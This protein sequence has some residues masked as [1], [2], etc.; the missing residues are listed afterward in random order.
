M[1][2]VK[3]KR[4]ASDIYIFITSL[5]KKSKILVDYK[6]IKQNNEKNVLDFFYIKN[7]KHNWYVYGIPKKT[8]CFIK[9]L[10]LLIEV[11]SKNKVLEKKINQLL[12][13]KD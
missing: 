11:D 1:D 2:N 3:I 9:L 4:G 5:I 13:E 12:N 6:L 10:D 8:N 7:C